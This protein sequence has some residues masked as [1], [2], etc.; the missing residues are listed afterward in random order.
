MHTL[1]R[2]EHLEW[3]KGSE[4]VPSPE[5]PYTSAEPF[6]HRSEIFYLQGVLYGTF[7]VKVS[8]SLPRRG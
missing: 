3:R 6:H 8:L 4:P 1:S 2:I 5:V 7:H